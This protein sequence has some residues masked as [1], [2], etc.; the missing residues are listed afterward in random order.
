M[1]PRPG[2]FRSIGSGAGSR[3]HAGEECP[4]LIRT[5]AEESVRTVATA[6]VWD[7]K[8]DAVPLVVQIS[9]SAL[10]DAA[11]SPSD[12]GQCRRPGARRTMETV[13]TPAT[14]SSLET[15]LTR[16]LRDP[17]PGAAAQQRF[18]P[19]PVRPGWAPDLTPDT[20]RRAAVL[21]LL[22]PGATGPALPLTVRHPDLPHH[23]GQ[24]SLPGGALDPGESPDA[25]ALRE[26]TEEI[27]VAA[28]QVRLLG[29]LSTLWIA[30]S[31]FV[32]TPARGRDRP[33]SGLPAPSPRGV[34]AP[35]APAGAPARPGQHRVGPTAAGRRPGRLPLSRGGR[36]RR[37]GC[38][39]DGPQ[40]VRLPV[41]SRSRAGIRAPDR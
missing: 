34:G 27:G 30:V 32:L 11:F 3:G 24:V 26:A 9:K 39:G 35:R 7:C 12:R 16:R 17:L 6:G 21:L 29:A 36:P 10:R 25:A 18:A 41:R 22:Y 13:M 19:I 23:A 5:H 2:S 4:P 14:L 15:F 8:R 38:D 33:A 20:A 31:N 40:R 37:L 1:R 28:G